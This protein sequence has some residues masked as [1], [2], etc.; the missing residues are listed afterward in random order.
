MEQVLRLIEN[1]VV[2]RV[3]SNHAPLTHANKAFL[4]LPI[5]AGVLFIVGSAFCLTGLYMWLSLTLPTY[6]AVSILGGVFFALSII[7]LIGFFSLEK[8]KA[9]KVRQ[10]RNHFINE[11]MSGIKTIDHELSNIDLVKDNP[12]MT[13][14][15]A[16]MA[17][18]AMARKV[19]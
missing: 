7:F 14:A 16:L 8:Y 19:A 3:V 15:S 10:A 13:C 6:Q 4:S 17:G 12:K 9:K 5:I 1:Y 18:Y 2:Q 11:I